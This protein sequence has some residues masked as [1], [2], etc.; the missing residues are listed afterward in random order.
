LDAQVGWGG[1]NTGRKYGVSKLE[2]CISAAMEAFVEGSTVE[3]GGREVE[4]LIHRFRRRIQ[5]PLLV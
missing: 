4:V 5:G 2:E 3:Q 1:N